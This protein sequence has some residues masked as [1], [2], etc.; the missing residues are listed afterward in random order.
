V[1]EL[2]SESADCESALVVL[3]H[4]R[5]LKSKLLGH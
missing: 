2:P 5:Q 3:R 4:V 1:V